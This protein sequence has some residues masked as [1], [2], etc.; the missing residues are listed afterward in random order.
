[1]VDRPASPA[2]AAGSDR[3]GGSHERAFTRA[4]IGTWT[5]DLATGTLWTS[6]AARAV[7]EWAGDAMPRREDLREAVHPED[8]EV[9]AE[10]MQ[11]LLATGEDYALGHRLLLPSGRVR[12]MHAVVTADVDEAG[13]VRAVHGAT[14]DVTDLWQARAQAEQERQLS[15]TILASLT[16]GY[17]LLRD[18]VLVETNDALCAM[19]GFAAHELIGTGAPYPY[20][21]A[22]AEPWLALHSRA[23]PDRPVSAEL[24]AVRC[25][26]QRLRVAVTVT[27]LPVV[28]GGDLRLVLFR[29]VTQDREREQTLRTWAATDPLTGVPNSRAFRDVLAKAV[30][31]HTDTGAPL[32]L[33]L[34][35]I[36]HFKQVNDQLGH[37]VG[38]EVLI[39]VVRR[40]ASTTRTAGLFA[41]V[42]GEEFALLMPGTRQ[43]DA[44][45]VL[46][47]ALADLRATPVPG[48]GTVTASAGVAQ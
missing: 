17:V 48:V 41:R 21:P 35:D 15:R 5:I 22:Q 28:E 2:A 30:L 1:M 47:R 8:R 11:R 45:H 27:L 24:D 40:L 6:A 29:D 10:H 33:A 4:G 19:T 25:D 42:G 16:E 23:A 14:L 39:E 9:V 34:L 13:D 37:A 26:G 32:S 18:G 38:D 3:R 20:W 46:E 36:D 31:E 7:M 43:E 44:R 12:H